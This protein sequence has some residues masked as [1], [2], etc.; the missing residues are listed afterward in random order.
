M[1]GEVLAIPEDVRE[2]R[3]DEIYLDELRRSYLRRALADLGGTPLPEVDLQ[4]L[5]DE[6]RLSPSDVRELVKA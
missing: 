6:T 4:F 3:I 1:P 2:L 5:A